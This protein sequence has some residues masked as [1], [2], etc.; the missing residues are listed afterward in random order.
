MRIRLQSMIRSVRHFVN[1][2]HAMCATGSA[3]E[4]PPE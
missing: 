2:D 1:V 3:G 4:T